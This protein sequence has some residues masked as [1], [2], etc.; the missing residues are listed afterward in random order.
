MT[1]PDDQNSD[2]VQPARYGTWASSLD[3]AQLAGGAIRLSEPRADGEFL[4]WLE[5]RPTAGG[6]VAV[7]SRQSDGSV[8]DLSP[9]D[10]NARTVVHEYGGGAW[11]PV[12]GA[13][14]A[15]SLDDQRLWHVGKGTPQ[16]PTPQPL[17]GEPA[18]PRSVR[19]ADPGAV[20]SSPWITYI[21]ERHVA[22]KEPINEVVGVH[23]LT[24]SEVTL[25]SGYDFYA[26]PRPS[27][28]GSQLAYIGWDHPNM[29][30][31]ATALHLVDL[32][33]TETSIEASNDRV[34]GSDAAWQQPQWSPTG[35]LH[36]V[37]DPDGWWNIH[38]YD[39][40]AF[41]P[42]AATTTE[43]GVPSWAFA[44]RTY[45]W[46]VDGTLWAV[47]IHNGTG[48]LG[49]IVDGSFEPI[50]TEFTDFEGLEPWGDLIVTI[51][52]SPTTAPA[53]ITI[54]SQ[55][56]IEILHAPTSVPLQTNDISVAVPIEFPTDGDRT[57]HA[58]YYPPRNP[59][60]RGI[61]SELPPVIVLSHG[62]PTGGS[63]QSLNLGIQYWTTRG[64][65]V[66][67]VNYGGS[68][69]FGTEYRNR[70]RGSWGI[71]DV[72][73]CVRAAEFLA[74]GGMAD[75]DRLVIK[76]GSAG[77]YTTLCALTFHRTFAAGISRYGVADLE[78][79]A[80]DT[81]KFESRYL[82]LLVGPWPEASDVYQARSPIHHTDRLEQPMIILQGSED[83]IVPPSQ[84][85]QMV[86]AL[87]AARV[88]HAY[89]LF[90]GESHG[91]RS[92]SNISRALE[93]ELSFL[94][95]MLD[96]AP[97]DQFEPVEIRRP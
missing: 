11:L 40:A 26:A 97:A 2:E 30:W 78:T 69:G 8:T 16:A 18:S 31:D 5:G 73:D 95:Q 60:Y 34:I 1:N 9:P 82:D 70:L 96:F 12:N 22:D 39:D 89:V 85:E 86:D 19:F 66:V 88:P 50:D 80:R 27:P 33:W 93:V 59:A 87:A 7:V 17:T 6:A 24:G 41:V 94:G 3:A 74:A 79:L 72:A 44:N 62:G 58:F 28:D 32:S 91:F 10:F 29:P 54:D 25:A 15:S 67:D 43:F 36:V 63:G 46:A 84:A 56:Q 65:G 64:I 52:A 47:S 45:C 61:N 13:V 90:E 42:V 38:R 53:V 20:R 77:G 14:I 23:T 81:H 48:S 68:T 4:G 37:G 49:R 21:R 83:P 57:A 35:V 92:A 55:D 71:T 75:P 51:A 76:G